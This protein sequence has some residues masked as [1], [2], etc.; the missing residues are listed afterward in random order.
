M[1][2]LLW[3]QRVLSV[4]VGYDIPR[5]AFMDGRGFYDL[6]GTSATALF[7]QQMDEL[8][9]PAVSNDP[10]ARG[11]RAFINMHPMDLARHAKLAIPFL[12][13]YLRNTRPIAILGM[14]HHVYTAL[15]CD[16]L[17]QSWR[18]DSLL[19]A[20]IAQFL[21]N[22]HSP[23]KVQFIDDLLDLPTLPT[24]AATET[25][26]PS[27]GIAS[28]VQYHSTT[29]H[30]FLFPVISHCMITVIFKVKTDVST[31]VDKP[32]MSDPCTNVC[33]DHL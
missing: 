7:M 33:D 22:I 21:N 24:R 20:R 4:I 19:L 2:I 16:V 23:A 18:S 27:I 3:D 30:P 17:F 32:F 6:G 1:I 26:S 5:S 8:I 11:R 31:M 14:G 25:F 13:R 10:Q 9:R 12:T 15:A 28:I 29:T